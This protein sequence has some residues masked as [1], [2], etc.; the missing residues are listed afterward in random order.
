MVLM[1][2]PFIIN[3]DGFPADSCFICNKTPAWQKCIEC[4]SEFNRQSEEDTHLCRDCTK[5]LHGHPQR[6]HHEAH[7][8]MSE[9]VNPNLELLS[10]ICI[11]TSHYVCFTR[12]ED[13]WILFDSMANRIRKYTDNYCILHSV[14]TCNIHC[15]ISS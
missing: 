15:Y 3:Y 2:V 12:S 8:E 1:P 6:A 7:V 13:Q 10:V 9:D 11:E 14:I 5:L 4:A